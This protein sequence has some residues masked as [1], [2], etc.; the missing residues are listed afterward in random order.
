MTSKGLFPKPDVRFKK[1]LS[2]TP[3]GKEGRNEGINLDKHSI[4]AKII[5]KR[6]VRECR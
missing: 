2:L 5:S 6:R 1:P 3:M 4:D